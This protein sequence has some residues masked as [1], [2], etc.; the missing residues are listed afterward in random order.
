MQPEQKEKYFEVFLTAVILA[1]GI[2][3]SV[4]Y[5]GHKIVP[6]ADFGAFVRTGHEL[7]SFHL[8]SSFK[9]APVV[10]L[11]QAGLSYIAGGQHPNLTAGWLLNALLHPFV[12]ILFWVV[13]KKVIGRAAFWI[14]LIASI[15]PWL[16]QLLAEPIAETTLLFFIL[17]TFFFL[18]KRSRY[19][20]LFAAITTM[21]RYEGAALILAC[22]VVDLIESKTKKQRL[23]S[24]LYSAV[25]ALP[26][27]L[28]MLGTAVHWKTQGDTYYL[29]ELG[30]ASGG[31]FMLTEFLTRLW[32]VTFYPLFNLG[33]KASSDSVKLLLGL[34][35]IIALASFVFGSVWAL[36][37]R[38]WNIL[39]LLI[40]FVP[41]VI[42]H[43]LHSFMYFRF[44]VPISWIA[45]LICF[46]GLGNFWKLIVDKANPPKIVLVVLQAI[47]LVTAGVWL[48]RLI[49]WL[50]KIVSLSQR[51]ALLPYIAM[52]LVAVAFI[53]CAIVY[54]KKSLWSN[55]V[56]S[57]LLC[58]IIVSNQ[59]TLVSVVGNGDRDMEFKLLADWYVAN[60]K[61]G[62]KMVCA[63]SGFLQILASRHKDNFI[64]T[65]A[66]KGQNPA[67]F[68]QNCYQQNITY[69]VWD[70][71]IGFAPGDRYYQMWGM[72]NIA[73][74][75]KPQ[76]A[77]P[78]EFITQIRHGKRFVNIFRLKPSIGLKR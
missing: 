14:A 27:A 24:L 44:C 13:G 69:V 10:G 12:A 16:L 74:L 43:A 61:S 5:F 45:L 76:S 33:P 77:G 38:N 62:E 65:A 26:L 48:F 55:L 29:K 11:F 23:L 22:F 8:P 53:S 51:S 18:F 37:K 71:R 49:P 9:R 42:V 54:R 58:L 47:L 60:A 35:K 72:G 2:Y 73:M 40:F 56:I 30:A 41:Y 78:Y 67:E 64:Q 75:S 66:V 32:R 46:Y 1:F 31:K 3:H 39:A 36:C 50:G 68:V 15:N 70:S 4:L 7:L 28:W 21:V 57:V 59:M 34:S 6:H 52:A 63:M 25:A 19:C 20:Y 17:L